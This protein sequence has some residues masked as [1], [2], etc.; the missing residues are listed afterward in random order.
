MDVVTR[1]EI[2]EL[3]R[4][5]NGS[6]ITIVLATGDG[7]LNR[8]LLQARFKK[9]LRDAEE[10]CRK[11]NNIDEVSTLL[12]PLI[13]LTLD[14]PFWQ[15]LKQS[16]VLYRSESTFRYF[17]LPYALKENLTVSNRF[18]LKYVLPVLFEKTS[19]YFLAISQNHV[20][21]FHG[22]SINLDE[23]NDVEFPSVEDVNETKGLTHRRQFHSAGSLTGKSSGFSAFYSGIGEAGN[24]QRED[25]VRYLKAIDARLCE[26]LKSHKEPLILAGVEYVMNIYREDSEYPN[27]VPGVMKF[28]TA[29]ADW[30]QI[31]IESLKILDK[32]AAGPRDQAI[33]FVNEFESAKKTLVSTEMKE[34]LIAAHEGRVESLLVDMDERQVGKFHPESGEVSFESDGR[35]LLEDCVRDA[36]MTKAKIYHWDQTAAILR[37]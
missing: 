11:D 30:K 31:H 16:L 8:E 17:K 34:I 6:C 4:N 32:L 22:D 12:K 21:L 2:D 26:Y 19:F 7:Q 24:E 29:T 27:I 35:D 14:L 9:F 37:Y 5:E 36:V 33:A 15:K 23:L 1:T 10:L 25:L 3:M 18:I 28:Q 20:R 13:N